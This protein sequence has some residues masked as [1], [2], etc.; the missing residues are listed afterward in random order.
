MDFDR[1]APF[2]VRDD[3]RLLWRFGQL[4]HPR[5][6]IEELFGQNDVGDGDAGFEADI[7]AHAAL[8]AVRR[9]ELDETGLA[10]L[11]LDLALL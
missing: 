2:E 7:L 3:A 4:D 6:E 10:V 9:G 11:G 1:L 8:H 5:L